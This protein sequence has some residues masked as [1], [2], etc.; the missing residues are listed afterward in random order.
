[1]F[2]LTLDAQA[3][4]QARTLLRTLPGAFDKAINNSLKRTLE[5]MRTEAVRKAQ[6][7]YTVKASAVR[8]AIK[9]GRVSSSGGQFMATGSRVNISDF[10]MT[11]KTRPKKQ[12]GLDVSVRRDTG[13]K[14][15]ARGFVMR[16]RNSGKA[17]GFM[18]VGRA[19]EDIEAITSP[20]IPQLLQN[21]KV[22]AAMLERAQEVFAK[23]LSFWTYKALQEGK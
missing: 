22:T 21:D 23:T 14:H 8:R 2:T 5:A 16:G 3:V 13:I 18:R 9:F 10:Y 7:V 20:A 17:L 12:R 4:D 11:P 6:E 1:M 19:R 15:I